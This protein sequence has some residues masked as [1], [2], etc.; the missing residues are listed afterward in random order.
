MDL[1]SILDI[2]SIELADEYGSK[3]KGKFKDDS[4]FASVKTGWMSMLITKKRRLGKEQIGGQMGD[5]K[6]YFIHIQSVVCGLVIS[7]SYVD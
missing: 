7:H 2:D 5:R 1:L 6:F 4:Q 3:R